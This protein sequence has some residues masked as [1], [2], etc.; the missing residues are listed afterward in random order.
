VLIRSPGWPSAVDIDVTP[1][2]G[3]YWLTAED[4]GIFAFGMA[5]FYGSQ[6]RYG[7]RGVFY[8]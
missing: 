6:P 4:G 1:D 5:P 3:G 2:G 8:N 7:C